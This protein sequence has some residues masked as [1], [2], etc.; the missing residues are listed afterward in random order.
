MILQTVTYWQYSHNLFN[1]WTCLLVLDMDIS[2]EGCQHQYPCHCMKKFT[3]TILTICPCLLKQAVQ[4]FFFQCNIMPFKMK[5]I[6]K[7]FTDSSQLACGLSQQLRALHWYCRGHEFK[8]CTVL[9]FFS[10][11][12][13]VTAF[14]NFHYCEDHFCSFSLL[15]S[16][17]VPNS[18]IILQII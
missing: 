13:F 16:Y 7:C 1:L 14:S 11:L 3:I 12:I 9:N 10:G 8:S 15:T 5:E 4:N 6:K 2:K 17:P 18:C